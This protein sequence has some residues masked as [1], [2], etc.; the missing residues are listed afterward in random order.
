MYRGLKS[1]QRS[2]L[3]VAVQAADKVLCLPMYPA[4]TVEDQ[5]KVI[6]VVTM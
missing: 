1:A 5:L 6:E 3:P 4:L 2:N